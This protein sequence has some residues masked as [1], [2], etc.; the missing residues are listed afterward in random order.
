MIESVLYL[1]VFV[2][3]AAMASFLGN[4]SWRL[5]NG[6]NILGRSCCEQCKR[7][8]GIVDLIPIVGY[9]IRR[10][11][12]PACGYQIPLRY[13]I[14][15]FVFGWVFVLGFF[16]FDL[17]LQS[18][19]FLT[20]TAAWLYLGFIFWVLVTLGFIVIYDIDYMAV[21][22]LATWVAVAGVL[23]FRLLLPAPPLPDWLSEVAVFN[24]GS[25]LPILGALLAGG[26]NALFVGA[27]VFFS[28]GRAMGSGDI[29]LA[30]LIGLIGGWPYG[31]LALFLAFII[32]ALFGVL[33][34]ATKQKDLQSRIPFGPFLAAGALI[35]LL[36]GEWVLS[37][38]LDLLIIG[39]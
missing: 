1:L 19:A 3:G 2:F 38:Y 17:L 16:H 34:I 14:T 8:L 26:I 4:L 37:T 29:G 20:A 7:P 11:Q 5:E 32:G 12:C 24:L 21:L 33:L 9:L 15:E 36:W 25:S 28:K 27:I 31:L 18:G 10:G 22:D 39:A 6:K 35:V 13:P 30:L 23:L